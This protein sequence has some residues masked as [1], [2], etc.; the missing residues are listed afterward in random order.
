MD[1]RSLLNEEWS[2]ETSFDRGYD[3][4]CSDEDFFNWLE[5]SDVVYSNDGENELV[6]DEQDS[7]VA[8]RLTKGMWLRSIDELFNFYQVHAELKW[9]IVVNRS[10]TRKK[11]KNEVPNYTCDRGGNCNDRK[12]NKRIACLT[13]VNASLGDD[14]RWCVNSL[15]TVHSHELMLDI[16]RLMVVHRHVSTKLKRT[17]EANGMASLQVCKN[18][19]LVKKKK[20]IQATVQESLTITIRAMVGRVCE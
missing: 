2:N 11:K 12:K 14:G 8:T 19:K 18:N 13:R 16:W 6:E 10:L 17:L 7:V 4:N 15:I 3:S 20:R 5:Y 1:Y 9:F